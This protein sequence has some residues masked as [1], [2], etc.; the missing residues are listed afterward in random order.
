V[1]TQGWVHEWRTDEAQTDAAIEPDAEGVY[2]VFC[3]SSEQ[4]E[5][6]G[7]ATHDGNGNFADWDSQ[8]FITWG[9]ENALKES[10]KCLSSTRLILR[11]TVLALRH[12]V[13]LVLIT[14]GT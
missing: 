10:L 8:F 11:L 7:N 6:A 14:T 5:A 3:R 12:T 1:F 2:T 9:E 4:A 13:P